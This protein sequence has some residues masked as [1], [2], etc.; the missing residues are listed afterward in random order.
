MATLANLLAETRNLGNR[1][2][3]NGSELAGLAK[4][5]AHH[6]YYLM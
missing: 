4:R 6:K 5:L 2:A 1:W 3:A